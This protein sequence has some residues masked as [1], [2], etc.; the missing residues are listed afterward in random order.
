MVFPKP[1]WRK[2][3]SV[4]IKGGLRWRKS[5]YGSFLP[6]FVSPVCFQERACRELVMPSRR[7]ADE[8]PVNRV[9]VAPQAVEAP[10]NRAQLAPQAA[11]AGRNRVQVAPLRRDKSRKRKS[12]RKS[13]VKAAEA[14]PKNSAGCT[15]CLSKKKRGD[16]SFLIW[17]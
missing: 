3:Q 15:T 11:E 1:G 17:F 8:P 14:G 16:S 10:A 6:G 5:N 4:S 9:Q 12:P 13:R 7:R 2:V